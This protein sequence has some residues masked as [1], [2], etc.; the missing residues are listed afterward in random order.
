ML[1]NLV[2]HWKMNDNAA[3]AT[4]VDATGNYNG[5]YKDK[6]G[7]LNTDTG[8]S[9]G[10][11]DGGLDF[12]GWEEDGG[13]DEHIDTGDPFQST[14]QSSFSISVWIKPTDGQPTPRSGYVIGE[15]NGAEDDCVW[16]VHGGNGTLLFQ[17]SSNGNQARFLHNVVV[18]NDGQEDWHHLVMVVDS[19]IRG[20]GGVKGYLDGYVLPVGVVYKGDTTDVVSADFASDNNLYI[21]SENVNDAA[22]NHYNGL[23]DNVMIFSKALNQKE[24]RRLYRVGMGKEQLVSMQ[25][26]GQRGRYNNWSRSRYR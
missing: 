26:R 8:D 16:I 11:I 21:G 23:I 12:D 13:T 3:T 10:R 22:V 15:T 7:D 4:V 25:D 2:A 20:I 9:T 5:T 6:D 19:T 14:F 24:V 17:Y 18:F 1:N